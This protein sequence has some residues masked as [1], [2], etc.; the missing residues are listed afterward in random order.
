MQ[1]NHNF[2]GIIGN[3]DVKAAMAMYER[4]A[5]RIFVVINKAGT[6]VLQDPGLSRPW[7]STNKKIADEMAKRC[8]HG[9]SAITLGEATRILVRSEIQ[10]N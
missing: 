10:K 4:T 7:S 2:E 8:G 3:L 5:N 1:N 6:S 9:A